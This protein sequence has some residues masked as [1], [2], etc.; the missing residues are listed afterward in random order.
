[1]WQEP[2]CDAI[3]WDLRQAFRDG[4]GPGLRDVY[5]EGRRVL[6]RTERAEGVLLQRDL[7]RQLPEETCRCLG[8]WRNDSTRASAAGRIA[9]GVQLACLVELQG[10]LAFVRIDPAQ[11]ALG[12]AGDPVVGPGLATPEPSLGGPGGLAPLLLEPFLRL[13]PLGRRFEGL[14]QVWI[15]GA[16][17]QEQKRNEQ[18]SRTSHQVTPS[19]GQT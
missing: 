7:P 16:S 18:N 6:P 8:R 19:V 15:A 10:D 17:C 4:P 14:F 9:V 1:V 12:A 5:T 3:C 13:M 2:G 11:N